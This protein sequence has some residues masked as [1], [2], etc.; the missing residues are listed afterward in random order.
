MELDY[1]LWKFIKKKNELT[2]IVDIYILLKV[3]V[4]VAWDLKKIMKCLQKRLLLL[5]IT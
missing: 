2:N 3:A 5:H 1:E 4:N